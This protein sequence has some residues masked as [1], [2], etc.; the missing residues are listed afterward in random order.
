MDDFVQLGHG[1]ARQLT[2]LRH[3]LLHTVDR[4]LA[5]PLPDKKRNEA[6]SLKKLLAG[7]GSWGTRKL[8]L[9]WIID[10]VRQTIELPPHQK[11]TLHQIFTKLQGARLVS[12]KRWRSILGK[13]WFVSL[14]IPGSAS[15]LA[16][17]NGLRT[18]PVK[19]TFG[20]TQLCAA[21]LMHLASLCARP[22]HLAELVPKTRSYFVRL[23]RRKLVWA[24]STSITRVQGTIGAYPF[25]M[26]S[27]GTW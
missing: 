3:H 7:D 22:T 5:R 24:A 15:L 21:I 19:I 13:V 17:C 10:S 11:E 20:S 2:M 26:T 1:K 25:R 27:S 4:I 18:K 9:G 12:A 23:T 6:V 16:P 8:I 14:A